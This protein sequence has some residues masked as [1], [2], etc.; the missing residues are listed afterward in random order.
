MYQILMAL[1]ILGFNGSP[2]SNSNTSLL[3]QKALEGARSVGAETEYVDLGKLSF[4][5]CVSCLGCKKGKGHEGTCH[6]HDALTPYL[7]KIKTADGLVMGFPV[8]MGL[9]SALFHS[10]IER[11]LYSNYAYRK[12]GTVFGRKIKTGL[13]VTMG[14]PKVAA[15]GPYKPMIQL[16]QGVIGGTYGSCETMCAC[17]MS[18]VDDYSKYDIQT[19][20]PAEKQRI[21]REEFPKELEKAYELGKRVATK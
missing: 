18:L 16:M 3:I 2:R 5:P 15:E 6:V 17:N 1:K 9:P 10:F 14:A 13:I 7:N 21:R 11:A 19:Q 20:N 8:Y 12:E 4:H